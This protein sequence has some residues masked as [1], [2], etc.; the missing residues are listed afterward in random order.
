MRLRFHLIQLFKPI[1]MP[2]VRLLWKLEPKKKQD[3]ASGS[4]WMEIRNASE[5]DPLFR[6]WLDHHE[7]ISA[8]EYYKQFNAK[9]SSNKN[10]NDANK[11]PP[12]H[13]TG[14]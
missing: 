8:E 4:P 10:S 12:A 11:K 1:V 14:M 2:L 9:F 5:L 13:E 7:D 3:K 6:K